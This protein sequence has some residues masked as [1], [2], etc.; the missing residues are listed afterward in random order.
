MLYDSLRR[1][2]HEYSQRI[3]AGAKE[4]SEEIGKNPG[5]DHSP[6]RQTG[7]RKAENERS[8]TAA[9]QRGTEEALGSKEEAQMS[10]FRVTYT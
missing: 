2:P 6:G 1:Q 3:E 4:A 9:H 8:G 5:R 10:N 7:E